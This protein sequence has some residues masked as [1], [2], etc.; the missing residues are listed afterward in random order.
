MINSTLCS[1][2][3]P[4]YRVLQKFCFN[5]KLTVLDIIK[6]SEFKTPTNTNVQCVL[7]SDGAHL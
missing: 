6:Q 1:S 7:L 2:T 5:Y 3:L 4:Q